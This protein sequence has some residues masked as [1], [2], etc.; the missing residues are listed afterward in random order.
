MGILKSESGL[1]AYKAFFN[2]INADVSQ[3]LHHSLVALRNLK[4]SELNENQIFNADTIEIGLKNI[5]VVMHDL[6]MLTTD[7]SQ[8]FVDKKNI[9][10]QRMLLNLYEFNAEKASTHH[11]DFRIISDVKMS[12]SYLGDEVKI[13]HLLSILLSNAIKFTKK[14]DVTIEVSLQE[15]KD[16]HHRLLFKISDTGIGIPEEIQEDI[17]KPFFTTY[18][19]E[20]EEMSEGLGL[21]I[22]KKLAFVLQTDIHLKSVVG[23]GSEFS[24]ELDL[25]VDDNSG[26]NRNGKISQQDIES[27]KQYKFLFADDSLVYRK[28][29]EL[30]FKK[31]GLDLTIAEDGYEALNILNDKS[32][33]L[34]MLDVEMPS[35]TGLEATQIIRNEWEVSVPIL[36]LT[37]H[38]DDE[39]KRS[40][41][42]EG[43]NMVLSK[44]YSEDDLLYTI[45]KLIEYS[46]EKQK[47]EDVVLKQNL[48]NATE[49][50]YSLEK[51]KLI[52]EDD[53]GGEE[54]LVYTFISNTSQLLVALKSSVTDRVVCK[55]CIHT[56]KGTF[57]VFG[58]HKIRDKIIELEK[59]IL[60][61]PHYEY[62]KSVNEIILLVDLLLSQMKE[63]LKF[64]SI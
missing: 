14:G 26:Y 56:F 48:R 55:R 47:R 33:D 35:I 18:Q 60:S 49:K 15:K 64:K 23:K 61:L 1:D 29:L 43:M 40:F 50:L 27:L 32:F 21:A 5:D 58:V 20:N 34:I 25:L 63:D 42:R 13:M 52:T 2:R 36:A 3:A 10:I 19:T 41:I 17:F 46:K 54:E 30:M 53:P 59:Q 7:R 28:M 6:Y 22:A 31:H 12:S 4:E 51:I 8:I 24:F 44:P 38:K 9:D 11:I 57:A 37:G 45:K 16:L 62:L 39:L